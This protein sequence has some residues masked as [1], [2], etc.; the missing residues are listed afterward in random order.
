MKIV[1]YSNA[2]FGALLL[3]LLVASSGISFHNSVWKEAYFDSFFFF[4]GN[5]F[6]GVSLKTTLPKFRLYKSLLPSRGRSVD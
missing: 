3:A 4:P 6:L 2:I 1:C 5:Y